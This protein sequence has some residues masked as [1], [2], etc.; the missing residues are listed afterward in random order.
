MSKTKGR[1]ETYPY[2]MNIQSEIILHK[3]MLSS[4]NIELFFKLCLVLSV[5]QHFARADP[6]YQ[7]CSNQTDSVNGDP[8]LNNLKQLLLSIPSNA[9]ASKFYNTSFGNDSYRGYALYLCYHFISNDKCKDCLSTA[10]KDIQR[11]CPND[12]EAV[13]WEDYCQLRYSNKSFFG[14]LD[15][16]G[17]IPKA[18]QQNVLDP[19]NFRSTVNKSLS[20]LTKIAAYDNSSSMYATGMS[21]ST[22]NETIYGFV[23]CTPDLSPDACSMCLEK[24][25]VDTL[26]LFYFSRGARLL[27]RSCYLRYELY[28]FLRDGGTGDDG[29]SSGSSQINKHRNSKYV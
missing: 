2:L 23:Q 16:T 7:L 18:N 25:M 21:N 26:S 12:T 11:L 4:V 29:S 27:S 5:L 13:V 1:R 14:Q 28:D 6:P 10:T 3:G 15:T 17:N 24:A 8:F 9:S 19:I 22:V 20:N